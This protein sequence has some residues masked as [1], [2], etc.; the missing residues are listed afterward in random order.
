MKLALVLMG[1]L[2]MVAT[3]HAGET[4]YNGIVLPDQWPPKVPPLTLEPL[5]PPPYLVTPPAV[6]PIDVGRQLLVD[7]FLVE[8]TTL[9]RTHHL[10]TWHPATPVI[11]PDREWEQA[12][13]KGECEIYS[14]GVWWD[15]QAQHFKAWYRTHHGAHPHFQT[16]MAISQDGVHWEKPAFDVVPGTNV[17]LVDQED[18]FRDSCTVWLDLFEQDPAR[19]FKIFRVMVKE[20]MEGDVRRS[21]KWMQL[22]CSPDGVHW[23]LAGESD[24]CGDRSTVSYNPFRAKW[25]YGLRSGTQAAGRTRD[26]FEHSDAVQGLRW[27]P[28]GRNLFTP[29][30]AA[31]TLD[32]QR[33]D[34]NLE[35]PVK[36]WDLPPVQLYN[37][38]CVAYES[39]TL[40]LF[41]IWR[42]QPRDRGKPNS[43]C[44]GYS[45]DGFHW[46][47]PDRRPFIPVSEHQ[48]DWNWCN[49]Q[50]VGGCCAIVG[51]QLYFY[52]KGSEGVPGTKATGRAH[53]GLAVLRRDGFT[54]MNAGAEAGTLT[55]RPVTFKGKFLFVNA[56]CPQGELRAEVLD[57]AGQPIKPFTRDKCRPVKLDSTKQMVRWQGGSDLGK[58]AGKPVR[59]RLHLRQGELYAFWVSPSERGASH[60]YVA[61][62]GPGFTGPA[63]TAD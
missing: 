9:T 53:V 14:D 24:R 58:L 34:L 46:S 2:P 20:W 61:A 25:V 21:N 30:V 32:P 35:D 48:G 29:W 10:T 63:D 3:A 54:S 41:A 15:P 52:C 36:S 23:T 11:S 1:V 39:L 13:G 42:G 49:V 37:L 44:V 60:G 43:L 57:E 6:I 22:H 19:R 59:F 51:D 40:G 18:A 31:D 8:S 33:H 27:E 55:T 47:R 16:C 26:Y 4:L 62:G 5:P 38:D 45:R 12:T 28:E 7:D 56:N 50:S 17:V